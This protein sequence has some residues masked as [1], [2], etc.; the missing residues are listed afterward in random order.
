MPPERDSIAAR[1]AYAGPVQRERMVDAGVAALAAGLTLGILASDGFGMPDPRARQLDALGI[2]LALASTLPL[3]ARRIAP[4]TVYAVAAVATLS[5]VFLRFPLDLPVGAGIA[6]YT[7]AVAYSGEPRRPRYWLSLLAVLAFTPAVAVGYGLIGFDVWTLTPEMLFLAAMFVGVWIAGDRARLRGERMAQLEELAR[8]TAREAERE[9]RLAAAEERTRIA[10]ELHDAAGHAIN[11]ILV[12]A[13]AARLLHERDAE[14]SRAAI[15]TI[16]EVARGTIGEID[17]L[18]RAL[19]E[20]DGFEP[21][22]PADASALEELV[23][24]H[25]AGGLGIASEIAGDHRDLPRGVAWAAYRILQEALTNAARH[26]RGSADV[27]IRLGPD[28]VRITVS[29]PALPGRATGNGVGGAGNGVGGAGNGVGGGHGIVGM[30][31]RA[32]LLGGEL[33]AGADDG[34]FRLSARLPRAE[35]DTVSARSVVKQ[36]TAVT[37]EGPTQ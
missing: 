36:S 29:N 18:V 31:E 37:N 14:G 17:R 1:A 10:R 25:R 4:A 22:A 20:D 2:L 11:V 7:L 32:T 26:G 15:T 24:R 35:P 33:R 3:A 27:A 12:Q 8:R 13:G 28:D 23:E 5:L 34:V 9:R 16:E 6:G 21:P 19:R 30:R